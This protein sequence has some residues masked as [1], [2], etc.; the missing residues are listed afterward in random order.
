MGVAKLLRARRGSF[1]TESHLVHNHIKKQP[2]VC[3]AG[4]WTLS[5]RFLAEADDFLD[6]GALTFRELTV[7]L[8]IVHELQGFRNHFF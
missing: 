1:V 2:H 6:H 4:Q 5:A 7:F 3:G 8:Q